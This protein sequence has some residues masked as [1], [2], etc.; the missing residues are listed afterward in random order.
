MTIAH[1]NNDAV[2]ITF[3]DNT[4]YLYK[5]KSKLGNQ[6]LRKQKNKNEKN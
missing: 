2:R 3:L 4:D 1:V 5:K 6:I